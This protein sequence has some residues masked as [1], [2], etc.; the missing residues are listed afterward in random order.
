MHSSGGDLAADM[1][2]RDLLLIRKLSASLI[3]SHGRAAWIIGR[4]P[5]GSMVS[6]WVE[7]DELH[8]FHRAESTSIP[9][10]LN[11]RSLKI[12][13]S[14]CSTSGVFNRGS[15]TPM[16]VLRVTTGGPPKSFL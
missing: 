4:R 2:K 10:F 8:D 16:G 3:G 7:A 14:E 12:F 1:Y 9:A 11:W 5:A 15:G 6:D 13:A